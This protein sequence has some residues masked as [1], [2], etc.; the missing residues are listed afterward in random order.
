M[1]SKKK[2]L[3]LL[4]INLILATNYSC[5][6]GNNTPLSGDIKYL[7]SPRKS[8]NVTTIDIKKINDSKLVEANNSFGT[9]LF[10]NIAKEDMKKNV[11]MSPASATMAL[12]MAYNGSDNKTKEEMAK[13]LEI[14]KFSLEELNSLNKILSSKLS[15]P[16]ADITLNVANS[17]WVDSSRVE[18]SEKFKKDLETFYDA[19]AQNLDFSTPKSADIINK[20][21]EDKTFG[22]IKEV[23][24]P[25]DFKPISE[26][27]SKVDIA[28]LINALYFKANWK[29]KFKKENTQQRDFTLLDGSKVK[30]DFMS[31]FT[32]FSYFNASER[33]EN[34][35]IIKE[36]NP[37]EV[38][39]LDYGKDNRVSLYIFLPASTSSLEKFY[40]GLT[41]EKIEQSI[42][43]VYYGE[44][45]ISFP[46]FK[47][48]E[49]YDLIEN[50][51]KQGMTLPFNR[52]S[53]DFTK[54]GKSKVFSDKDT[55]FISKVNQDV[56]IDVNEEGSEAAAV[57]SIG[58]AVP[59]SASPQE[60]LRFVA[61]RPFFYIIRDNDIKANLFM[62]SMVNPEYK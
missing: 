62:G 1:K 23:V 40:D 44:G 34:G 14:D 15:N 53:A 59:T 49:K 19:T 54:F 51:K 2:L 8:F 56:F 42:N 39:K 46:K 61:D 47:F 29:E 25:K 18:L 22:K 45:Q 12:Q 20:W 32:N 50:L 4:L 7:F 41:S 9:K 5:A 24:D 37:F 58:M 31:N 10:L 57:T 35:K 38:A 6:N 28:Y 11:F 21:C 55:I 13:A 17:L 36:E 43:K 3:A 16:A 48:S 52:S 33:Y 60:S 27:G 26:S 30:K